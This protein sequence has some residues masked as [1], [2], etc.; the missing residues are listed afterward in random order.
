MKDQVEQGSHSKKPVLQSSLDLMAF[1]QLDITIP[2]V[3][4]HGQRARLG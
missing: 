4:K 1:Y 3:S 2:S